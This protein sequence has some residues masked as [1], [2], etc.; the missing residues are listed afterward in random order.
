MIGAHQVSFLGLDGSNA[1]MQIAQFGRVFRCLRPDLLPISVDRNLTLYVQQSP[2]PLFE[3]CPVLR[4]DMFT[5]TK[6]VICGLCGVVACCTTVEKAEDALSA[7]SCFNRMH[8]YG[9]CQ[10]KTPQ[11]QNV[12]KV[13]VDITA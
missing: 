13:V 9:I 1:C 6:C 7:S 10:Q 3:L 12:L 8:S 4:L 11:V 5:C 2:A